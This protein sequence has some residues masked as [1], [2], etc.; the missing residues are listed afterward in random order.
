M[1][2]IVGTISALFFGVPMLLDRK[3][4]AHFW[5]VTVFG[6]RQKYNTRYLFPI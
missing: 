5:H 2:A 4:T 1:H 6:A 3:L